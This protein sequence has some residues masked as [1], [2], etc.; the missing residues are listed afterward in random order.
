MPRRAGRSARL[1]TLSSDIGP[2]Y[3]A[4]VK[5]VLLRSVAPG[6]LCE[7]TSSLP[8]HAIAEGAF[9]LRAMAERF[10]AGTV[11]LAIVDPGV[12]GRRA[13]IA[14]ACADGSVLVGPDN[15]LLYP[16]AERLGRPVA[17]RLVPGRGEPRER[18]GTTFDARDLFAPAAAR[19]ANGTPPARLGRPHRPLRFRLPVA[20]AV[21]GG[22]RGA[23]LL[24]DHFGNVITNVPSGWVPR[25]TRRL[26]ARLGRRRL[27]LPWGTSYEALGRGRCG[28]IGSS[29]G[30]VEI[31]RAEGRAADS[32]GGRAGA[33]ETQARSES[34]P[35][36]IGK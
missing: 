17:Y 5:A 10:P 28:A 9:L 11:H 13:P 16:L 7:L 25:G 24:V 6:R 1:L 21:A 2:E 22:A 26:V 18:I 31:A 33:P 27:R 12:G 19:I 3:A 23:V 35:R 14:L 15:G 34:R 32:V 8:A 36:R 4:Q 20:Q 30:T 29:F